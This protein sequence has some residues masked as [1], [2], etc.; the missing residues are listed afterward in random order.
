MRISTSF[1]CLIAALL[2]GLGTQSASA[3][4]AQTNIVSNV[5]GLAS[6]TDPNLVNPWGIAFSN[7]SPVWVANEGSGVATLYTS[8]GT[9]PLV[10]SIPGQGTP[11]GVVFNSTSDFLLT[12]GN[13]QKALFLFATK[14]GQIAG[15]NGGTGAIAA[16]P[17]NPNNVYT[18][19]TAGASATG[20]TLYAANFRSGVINAFGPSFSP[21]IPFTDPNVPAGYAP[22]NVENINGEL[23]VAFAKQDL[24]TDAPVA[25][26]GNGFIDVFDLNGGSLQRLVSNGALDAP[27]GMAVAPSDFG[28]FGGDLL[29]GNN[30]DGEIN[31]FNITTGAFIGTL[32]DANGNPIV[33]PALFALAFGNGTSFSSDALLFTA[34]DGLLGEIQVASTPL[35]AT[36]PMFGSVLGAGGLV[37]W[38]RKRKRHR[39][40]GN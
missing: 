7:T 40:S 5:P 29:V 10:V 12:A 2:V 1:F 22:F 3:Q 39:R 20:N 33:D 8:T 21:L 6:I 19:L 36:L 18:G 26:A 14:D 15:W 31:A 4:Y 32:E 16:V 13:G 30:G 11:T 38:L 27:W 25:G 37:S 34:G 28:S 23:Y 24:A 17:A 9:V 35:P